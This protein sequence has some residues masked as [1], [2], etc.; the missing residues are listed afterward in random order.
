[1]KNFSQPPKSRPAASQLAQDL[2]SGKKEALAKAITLVESQLNSDKLLSAELFA[3]L[4]KVDQKPSKRIGITGVPGVGKSS[5]IEAIGLKLVRQGHKV[6]VLS[7]DPSSSKT[8]GSLL[9]D[10]SRMEL[11]SR[12]KH[13]FIRPSPTAGFMGGVARKTKAA[14]SLCEAAGFDYILVET[15]GAGQN[16]FSVS[17]M[18]D[19][20]VLLLLPA[21]GDELQGIKRG[22]MEMADA[23]LVNKA[24]GELKTK[25]EL[26]LKD[27]AA[28]ITLLPVQSH[29]LPIYKGTV[30][31]LTGLG[32]G[33][34]VN[35]LAETSDALWQ[36][37]WIDTHRLQQNKD[38]FQEVL[39]SSIFDAV[40]EKENNRE[41]LRETIEKLNQKNM[42]TE[43]AMA[44]FLANCKMG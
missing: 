22:I 35:W 44:Y 1:M 33:E 36:S 32:L 19:L 7:I 26:T 14:I 18:V 40:M 31:A 25:A 8:K 20:F 39:K 9:G 6:A 42:S 28:A 5:L 15:V 30:S 12:E 16:E 34:F 21:G 37:G 23:V 17:M 11:L 2:L 3:C 27:Y 10:K 4:E 38:W 13:A 29:G 43:T 41:L 24:D